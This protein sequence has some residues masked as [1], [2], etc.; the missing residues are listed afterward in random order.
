MVNDTECGILTTASDLLFS[1]GM[2][3]YFFALDAN[4]GQHLWN[5]NLGAPI[6]MG[7]I[8]YAINRHEYIAVGANSGLF[9]FALKK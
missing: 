1:G 4:T 2:E 9:V 5:I 8:A 6:D 3:G 7:P